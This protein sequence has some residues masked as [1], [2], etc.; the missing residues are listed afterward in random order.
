MAKK[1]KLMPEQELRKCR[2]DLMESYERWGDLRLNG[3]SDPAWPDGAN[4][5]LA[6]NHIMYYRFRIYEICM[7]Q[8]WDRPPEASLPVPPEAPK[9]YMASLEQTERVERLQAMGFVL[10]TD[11]GGAGF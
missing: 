5:E 8:G 9:G 6:R 4:M 2:D 10:T 11:F 7:L 1:K 3:G